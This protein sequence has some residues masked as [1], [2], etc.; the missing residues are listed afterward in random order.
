M[1]IILVGLSAWAWTGIASAVTAVG[2]YGL[3]K[4]AN[5]LQARRLA[6]AFEAGG[7]A[8]LRKQVFEEGLATS[9]EHADYVVAE[10]LSA[11]APA[12][13]AAAPTTV[14]TAKAS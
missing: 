4:G 8:G 11:L 7:H 3:V 1:P 10:I 12:A 2:G 6:K 13:I 5:V 14:T 9:S